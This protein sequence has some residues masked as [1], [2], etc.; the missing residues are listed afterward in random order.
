[1]SHPVLSAKRDGSA[2]EK[3]KLEETKKKQNTKTYSA[4]PIT[5]LTVGEKIETHLQR[6]SLSKKYI[7]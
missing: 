6:K 2:E 1:M 4:D 3:R 7:L 5:F